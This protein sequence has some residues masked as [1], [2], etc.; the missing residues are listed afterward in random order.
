MNWVGLA[1]LV[2]AVRTPLQVAVLTYIGA[3][4][5]AGVAAVS[6]VL[7]TPAGQ[8]VQ[9][10]IEPARELVQN[11]LPADF[12]FIVAFDPRQELASPAAVRREPVALGTLKSLG[13][14]APEP[15]VDAPLV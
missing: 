2:A 14:S 4:G 10:A 8:V 7:L 13:F 11:I 15:A 1:G 3:G 12:P 5:I 6:V 9:Q